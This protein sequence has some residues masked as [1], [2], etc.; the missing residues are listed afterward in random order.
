M[1]NAPMPDPKAGSV[2]SY[3]SMI[4]KV[5]QYSWTVKPMV[6]GVVP[7]SFSKADATV[8]PPKLTEPSRDVQVSPELSAKAEIN[9]DINKR[10]RR[11]SVVTY[12]KD[13]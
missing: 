13:C 10:V 1:S 12:A 4:A 9:I 3:K 6:A 8:Y 5:W 2:V 7:R 11:W